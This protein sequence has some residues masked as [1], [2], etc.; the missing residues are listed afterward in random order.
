MEFEFRK[1]F[2]TGKATVQLSMEQHAFAVWLEQEGQLIAWLDALMLKIKSLQKKEAVEYKIMGSE[3]VLLLTQDEALV[4][5]HRLFDNED[6][7]H[8]D[9]LLMNEEDL[10]LYNLEIE[11]SCGL[12]DF[13]N[14]I[15]SWREFIE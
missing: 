13:S 7:Q 1:D 10:S 4:T 2:I 15:D 11:A 8:Q 12:E 3:F 9:E 14:L 6:D 5:H